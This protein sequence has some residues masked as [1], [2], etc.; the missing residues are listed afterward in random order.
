VFN[1]TGHVCR[2]NSSGLEK[3]TGEPG[4]VVATL[5]PSL[6]AQ[7]RFEREKTDGSIESIAADVLTL[8]QM[9]QIRTDGSERKAVMNPATLTASGA[10]IS[11]IAEEHNIGY[12]FDEL[13]DFFDGKP[14]EPSNKTGISFGKFT[15]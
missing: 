7:I 6:M 3:L 13:K 2:V 11:H 5:Y 14:A 10:Y 15:R 12:V 4:S 1:E 8:I 9:R